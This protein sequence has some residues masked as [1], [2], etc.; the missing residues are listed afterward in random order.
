MQD[1]VHET[2]TQ[3][4]ARS[5]IIVSYHINSGNPYSTYNRC[6]Y[7]YLTTINFVT[8]LSSGQSRDHT[9]LSCLVEINI[10]DLPSCPNNKNKSSCSVNS[11]L[12]S[13]LSLNIFWKSHHWKS[14]QKDVLW[15]HGTDWCAVASNT[16]QKVVNRTLVKHYQILHPFVIK[17]Q[18][19]SIKNWV[20]FTNLLQFYFLPIKTGWIMIS[21]QIYLISVHKQMANKMC[22]GGCFYTPI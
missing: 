13:L 7:L 4:M 8:E 14:Q 12:P 19:L 1:C 22:R 9:L 17:P 6:I 21:A 10:K 11:K 3:I 15:M 5:L 20:L 18:I 16:A 2:R